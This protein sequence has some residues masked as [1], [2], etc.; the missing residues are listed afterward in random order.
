MRVRVGMRV[1]G[2]LRVRMIEDI[3][4]EDSYL[5]SETK[6]KAKTE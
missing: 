3:G 4:R 5:E 2:G 1:M 6:A